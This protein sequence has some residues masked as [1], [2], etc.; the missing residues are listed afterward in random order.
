[1]QDL[2]GELRSPCHRARRCQQRGNHLDEAQDGDR[3]EEVD[4]DHLAGATGGHSELHD[5]DG[6]RVRGE[7][8]FLV[9]DHLVEGIEYLGL[10]ALV[11]H[12]G[13]DQEL[14]VREVVEVGGEADA[15]HRT[16]PV[17]LGQLVR[18]EGTVQRSQDALA[19]RLGGRSIH[20][21][22]DHVPTG[23]GTHFGDTGTHQARTHHT[24]S[25]DLVLR[26]AHTHPTLH[27]RRGGRPHLPYPWCVTS[28][29]RLP[30]PTPQA[31]T[32]CW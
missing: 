13:L 18:P 21:P 8:R 23:A 19:A 17:L 14:T 16:V 2:V 25:L 6:A 11:L 15:G 29:H 32:R 9:D 12:D 27:H 31:S 3:V 22:D 5:R 1:M 10:Q 30:R 4:T 28:A 7:D 26:F 24:D 20:L